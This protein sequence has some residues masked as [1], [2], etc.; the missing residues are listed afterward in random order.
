MIINT[1]KS[2]PESENSEVFHQGM[3][4]RM[5]M[6]FIKYGAVADAYPHKKSAIASL[7]LRLQKYLDT[8]NTEFLMDVANFAMIEFMKPSLVGAH[9]RAT[10]S[11][12][13]PGRV[14]VTGV[15]SQEANTVGQENLRRGGSNRITSGGFY[16]HEGD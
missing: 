14:S 11:N 3:V 6:S 15:V 9:F 13:S 1:N 4:S 16:K 5:E 12:E 2:I 7:Q 8:G 10:D